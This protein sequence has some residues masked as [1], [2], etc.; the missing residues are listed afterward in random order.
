MERFSDTSPK[1]SRAYYVRLAEMSPAERV[2]IGVSLW[3]AGN[4]LQRAGMRLRF[5]GVDEEEITFQ[6]A[7]VRFGEELARRIY[8]RF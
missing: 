1:A 5:P 8:G 4:A 6:V 2:N 7:V 3:E